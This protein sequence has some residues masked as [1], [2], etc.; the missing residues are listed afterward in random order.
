MS[1]PKLFVSYCWSSIDHEAWVVDLASSLRGS[2]VDV[3][4]DKWDLREGN[5]ANAFME[6]MVTDESIGKVILVCDKMYAEKADKRAG[7]VG[8][9]AQIISSELY[10]SQIQDKFV[11]VVKERDSNNKPFLPKYY[12]SRIY[13]DLSSDTDYADNYE[14][15]LRW[16]FNKPL[17]V[18]PEIGSVPD[19]L[20]SSIEVPKLQ[21]A[22]QFHRAKSLISEQRPN[23]VAALND[24]FEIISSEFE[25]LRIKSTDETFDEDVI[26]S[27]KS[28]T[29]CRNQIIELIAIIAKNLDT[30]D[31]RRIV[32]HFLES[33]L[34]YIDCPENIHQYAK[35]DFDNYKFIVHEL[36]LYVIAI[37]LKYEKFEF[38]SHLLSTHYYMRDRARFGKD[39]M[40]S[41]AEFRQYLESFEHRN[42]RLQLRKLSLR[43]EVLKDRA[44]GTGIEFSRLME[45]D[46]ILFVRNY[47]DNP[48]ADWHWWPETLLYAHDISGPLELFA[49]SRS[50]AY[51]NSMKIVVGFKTRSDVDKI[52]ETF[53]NAGRRFPSWEFHS[54]DPS[55]L[56]DIKNLATII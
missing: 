34:Q 53:K 9:E 24:Y 25:K 28:F 30:P 35:W 3:I 7:G 32:H 29:P 18:K 54:F 38:A 6:K 13:I 4:L 15:L 41:F 23:A 27:I 36:F 50:A 40:Y 44:A 5:D 19:F 43:A 33:I 45:A 31:T 21:G 8:T 11:A 51:F 1:N 22:P 42:R 20:T 46:F 39:V 49:R 47:N 55:R 2:G 16:I 10:S 56:M 14:K 52:L 48:E 26:E 17:Y 12:T 37:L